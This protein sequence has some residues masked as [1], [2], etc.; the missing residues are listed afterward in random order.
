VR[1]FL[2][3][4]Q[5]T[6]HTDQTLTVRF[7]TPPGEQAQCDWAEVGR[8]PQPDGTT[9]RVDAF[10]MVLGYS[11]YLYV[12]F[13]RSMSL[14]TLIRCHQNAFA[15][16]GGWPR[17]I[18]YDNMRQVVVGPE[19]I[20]AQFLDFTRHHGFEVKRCRPYRARTKGR[21]ERSVSYLRDSFLNGR[22]FAGL[23]DLNAQGRHWLGSVANVRL[24]GTTQARPCD[25]LLEETLTPGTGRN[26]YQVTHSIARTVGVE[27]LVRY[28]KSD[29]SVPARWVGTRVTVDA[30]DNVIVIRAK[31]LIVAEHLVATGPGQRAL[32]PGARA[33]TLGALRAHLGCAAVQGLPH[34]I[35]RSGAGASVERL[36]G[37][38][39]MS[40][41][42]EQPGLDGLLQIGAATAHAQLD[43]VAQQAA[44]GHW[45]YSHFL[46][47]LLEPEIA[48]RRQRVVDTSLHFSGLPWLKRLS[49][50]DFSF[51]PSIDRTLIEEL[52][53]GRF[54]DEG[55][56]V[57]FQGPPGVGKT[58]LAIALGLGCAERGQRLLF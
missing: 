39:L 21:V 13:T 50:F 20:N 51:Q 42:Y 2:H 30:G 29:Y 53:T 38:G 44:A 18:L 37:G 23:D 47:R 31:D 46:G 5:A 1:R 24:H 33:R 27:A 14:A 49:D 45:S 15:F 9:A 40:V 35:H 56:N 54:L 4:L 41:N 32:V 28:E 34:H 36:R 17:R 19:R 11:R 48:A 6:R 7:E 25:R 55:R 57:I 3:G 43:S 12:E 8:Y 16:F 26:P 52:G 22:T 58:H 10:V